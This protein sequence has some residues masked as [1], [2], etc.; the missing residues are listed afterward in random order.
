MP[1]DCDCQPTSVVV[2]TIIENEE[3]RIV[4]FSNQLFNVFRD[5]LPFNGLPNMFPFNQWEFLAVGG[6]ISQSNVIPFN[7]G[8]GESYVFDLWT[9]IETFPLNIN[10]SLDCNGD[11][12]AEFSV[13]TESNIFVE[14]H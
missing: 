14:C 13:N 6:F 8:V 10:T 12:I 9:N 1:A 3:I 11:G 2:T 4:Q 7:V 5:E